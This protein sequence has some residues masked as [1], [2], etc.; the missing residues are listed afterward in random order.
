[1]KSNTVLVSGLGILLAAMISAC[2]NPAPSK[3]SMSSSSNPNPAPSASS[4]VTP[5]IA[6]DFLDVVG[7]APNSSH[8]AEGRLTGFTGLVSLAI[9]EGGAQ[10]SLDGLTW[11]STI[12][13][14]D[15]SVFKIRMN[16]PAPMDSVQR[17][18]AKAGTTSIDWA[19]STHAA[20]TTFSTPGG[21]IWVHVPVGR[22]VR[23][24]CWG[25]GGGGGAGGGA[26]TAGA[27]GGGG[28]YSD[29]TFNRT[30]LESTE[31]VT[32]G[33]GGAQIN[34]GTNS[35]FG[36]R[37]AAGGGG[38]GLN[39]AGGST[40]GAGGIGTTTGGMVGQVTAGGTAGGPGGG[41]GGANGSAGQVPGGGGGGTTGAGGGGINGNGGAAGGLGAHGRCIVTRVP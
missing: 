11:S 34:R 32:V 33:S 22:S 18:V 20:S 39:A 1:M 21:H 15:S 9:T 12:A 16:A 24:Q 7:A 27:G 31:I 41:I 36:A 10:L 28:G 19:I 30:L 38:G 26:G 37:L 35:S 6:Q 14:L 40:P 2:S 8:T 29:Q 23:V 17:A 3:S 25:A 5:A 4:L 13:V